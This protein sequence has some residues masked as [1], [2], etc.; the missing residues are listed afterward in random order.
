MFK[1]EEK[2]KMKVVDIIFL[3]LKAVIIIATTVYVVFNLTLWFTTKDNKK[4]KRAAI[5]F[6]GAF[7][8]VIA[9]S[10]VEFYLL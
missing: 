1:R 6:G 5:A 9:L 10:I 7:L 8:S 3:L 4:L 2:I